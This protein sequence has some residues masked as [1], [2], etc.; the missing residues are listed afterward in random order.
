M[1]SVSSINNSLSGIQKSQFNYF[2]DNSWNNP[3]HTLNTKETS[4]KSS[5]ISDG[6]TKIPLVAIHI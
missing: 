4:F 6:N 5:P 1:I 2:I 3:I